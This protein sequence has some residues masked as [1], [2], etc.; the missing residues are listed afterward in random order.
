MEDPDLSARKHL[1]AHDP[2]FPA[3]REAA[4]GRIV[5]AVDAVLRLALI[6]ISAPTRPS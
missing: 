4:W 2:G 1:A 5:A 6:H 3:R